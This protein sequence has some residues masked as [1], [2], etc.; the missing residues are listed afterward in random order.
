MPP[1]GQPDPPPWQP[2]GDLVWQP[3][4]EE[5]SW[6]ETQVYDA[7]GGQAP[8][9]GYGPDAGYG[10]PAAG[11]GQPPQYPPQ[12]YP[13]GWQGQR[14]PRDRRTLLLAV[15]VVGLPLLAVLGLVVLM[16]RGSSRP[17]DA[18]R[19]EPRP[20]ASAD[21]EPTA[22]PTGEASPSP[23]PEATAITDLEGIDQGRA[24]GL[25]RQGGVNDAGEIHNAW[26]W[27][28]RNGLNL[29]ALTSTGRRQLVLKVTHLAH[30]DAQPSTLREMRDPQSCRRQERLDAGFAQGSVQVSDLDGDGIAEATVGWYAS[31]DDT[32]QA[33]V[34]LA[35]ISN[36]DKYILRGQGFVGEPPPG[37]PAATFQPEPESSAWPATFYD[38]TVSVFHNVF[39]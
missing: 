2:Q 14:P 4:P 25:L 37:V 33:T 5:P 3:Q 30:L 29:L 11:W 26:T 32:Q 8:A 22:S 13:G 10:P 24:D 9:T 21:L 16:P 36:G 1:V 12:Q 15:M 31:C 18:G 23:S 34:K 17:A 7:P 39:T 38:T 6:Q 35:L 19:Q 28:D 20:S 27:T